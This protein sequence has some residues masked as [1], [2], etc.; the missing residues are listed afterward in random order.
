MESFGGFATTLHV[1]SC[2][3]PRV[4]G[5]VFSGFLWV[6]VYECMKGS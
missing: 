2:R 6:C 1:V 3:V 4:L 5:Q